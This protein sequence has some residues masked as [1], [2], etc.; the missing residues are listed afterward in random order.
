VPLDLIVPDQNLSEF[1]RICDDAMTDKN[2]AKMNSR[3]KKRVNYA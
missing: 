2:P 3:G 1:F